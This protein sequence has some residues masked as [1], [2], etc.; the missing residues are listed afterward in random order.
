MTTFIDGPA[1]GQSLM[2]ARTPVLLRVTWDGEKWD[3]LDQFLDAPSKDE[4]V[5]VYLIDKILGFCHMDFRDKDGKRGSSTRQIAR[6][7]HLSDVNPKR[8]D[9]RDTIRWK[10]WCHEMARTHS[11]VAEAMRK[12]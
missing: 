12:R 2:L 11:E 10:D 4:E 1:E 3:A 6:Y 5:Y 9:L 7:R 8:M